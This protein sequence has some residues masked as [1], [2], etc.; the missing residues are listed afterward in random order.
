MS[1]N[2]LLA[3]IGCI[4]IAGFFG[5][6]LFRISRIPAVVLLMGIGMLVGP[7]FH[8]VNGETLFEVAPF[9]GKVA[10]L[11]ILFSGGLGLNLKLVVEQAGKAALLAFLGFGLSLLFVFLICRYVMEMEVFPSLTLGVLMGGNASAII[12][13]MLPGLRLREGVRLSLIHI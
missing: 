4:I 9:F 1:S 11:I 10:L 3:L 6:L 8:L 5:N 12:I 13:P 7:V 2:E